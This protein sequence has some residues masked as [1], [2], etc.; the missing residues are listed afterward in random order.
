MATLIGTAERD[1]KLHTT[2]LMGK[3]VP[4][5]AKEAKTKDIT[6]EH[7]MRH[8]SGRYWDAVTDFVTPQEKNRSDSV[9]H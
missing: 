1:G 8:C 5:W 7:V 3:Y 2:D 4:E 6:M 9:L